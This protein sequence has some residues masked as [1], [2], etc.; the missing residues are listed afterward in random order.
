MRSSLSR[1]PATNILTQPQPN[2]SSILSLARRNF[3][4]SAARQ[5]A[6]AAP[7][8][9][10]SNTTVLFAQ[11]RFAS[12]INGSGPVTG[13]SFLSAP[14]TSPGLGV[15]TSLSQPG[16]WSRLLINAGIVAGAAF[17]AQLFFNRPQRDHPLSDYATH[18]LHQTFQWLAGGLTLTA[19]S[20]IALHRTG[21]SIRLMTTSPWMV[22][23]LGLIT[24]IGGMI[25][26]QS[27]PTDSPA[28]YLCWGLFNLSQAAVL[29]PLL[30]FSPALLARAG[31][32]TA[33]VV[34]SLCYVGAT[35]KDD[36]FLWMGG[37]L[38]AGVTVVALSSLSPLILPAHYLRT[39]AVSEAL[40]LYG[41]LAVFGGF[42]L[43][44][45]QKVL[46]HARLAEQGVVRPD[47]L[48]E[49]IGL[50]L[51]FIN[52]FVRMVQILGMQQSRR[53]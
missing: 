12:N 49:S 48:R 7:K 28:K 39:L 27:L 34:G 33:G 38:L 1:K 45:C 19:L 5:A 9:R 14:H 29:S 37:P 4:S 17:A 18:Y 40:S 47:P 52:I 20:A 26:A 30:F 50:E 46:Q 44:D 31:L 41:G 16:G 8:G 6:P 21:F 2:S 42:I 3:T 11:R 51:D 32:Y 43:F 53:K 25:G 22:I 15:P 23:G 10:S 13:G 36:A 35:A 24:S